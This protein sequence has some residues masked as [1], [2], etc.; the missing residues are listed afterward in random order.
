MV[1]RVACLLALVAS[2]G[3]A[4]GPS[5]DTIVIERESVHLESRAVLSAEIFRVPSPGMPK[6]TSALTML[7]GSIVHK[8]GAVR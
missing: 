6:V 5:P 4:N 1:S 2:T 3:C 8:T 7:G